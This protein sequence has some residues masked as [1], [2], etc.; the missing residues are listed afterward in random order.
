MLLDGQR[1]AA[2]AYQEW[3]RENP[4]TLKL[5]I[6]GGRKEKGANGQDFNVLWGWARLAALTRRNKRFQEVYHEASYNLAK[7][8]LLSA[9]AAR[10]FRE[11]G[12][13]QE[14]RS[15]CHA[16]SAVAPGFRR[17][18][19]AQEIRQAAAKHPKRIGPAP[20]RDS[21]A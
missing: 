3:G 11:G 2:Y 12:L 18:R 13:A 8:Y 21:S 1:E 5:A 16:N 17:R 15:G 4:A 6:E 7:C 19:L 10:G 14:G 9:L 20:D